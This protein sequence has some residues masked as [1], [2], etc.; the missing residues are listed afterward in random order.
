MNQTD[1]IEESS[2]Y[3]YAK[4]IADD[5][6]NIDYID[7]LLECY[8]YANNIANYAMNKFHNHIHYMIKL[9]RIRHCS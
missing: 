5:A 2:E 6:M 7:K 8:N 3:I 9:L 1:K 4:N